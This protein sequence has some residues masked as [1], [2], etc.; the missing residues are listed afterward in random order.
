MSCAYE[1]NRLRHRAKIGQ[2]LPSVEKAAA[3]LQQNSLLTRKGLI[4][5][6][7]LHLDKSRDQ[8]PAPF[9]KQSVGFSSNASAYARKP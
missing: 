1:Y 2:A 9:L 4:R 5:C 7:A 3:T 8:L 6:P